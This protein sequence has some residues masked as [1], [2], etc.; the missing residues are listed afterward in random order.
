MKSCGSETRLSSDTGMKVVTKQ[1]SGLC[2]SL[3]ALVV[4]S[5]FDV[6]LEIAKEGLICIGDLAQK[7]AI[8]RT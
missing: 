6:A 8:R 7:E 1:V 5:I 4:L 2:R 3:Q